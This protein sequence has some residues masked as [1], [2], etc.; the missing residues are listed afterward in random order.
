M[1]K[2]GEL[3]ALKGLINT[4]RDK[5]PILAVSAYHRFEDLWA[6]PHYL[7]SVYPDCHL[8]LRSYAAEGMDCVLYAVPV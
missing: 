3:E 6:I 5:K 8:Y 2:G 4:I 7:Q 1:L